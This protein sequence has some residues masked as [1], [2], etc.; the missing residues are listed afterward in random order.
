MVSEMETLRIENARLRRWL[1][2]PL[3]ERLLDVLTDRADAGGVVR[4]V[5]VNGLAEAVYARRESVSRALR[6]LAARGALEIRRRGTGKNIVG[7]TLLSR[8]AA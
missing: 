2:A 7:L 1:V 8:R 4:S 3:E 5:S 6:D